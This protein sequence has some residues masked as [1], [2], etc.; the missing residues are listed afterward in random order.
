MVSD[1]K[2]A[3][4]KSM[5]ICKHPIMQCLL[6]VTLS[7]WAFRKDVWIGEFRYNA[8]DTEAGRARMTELKQ[9][10]KFRQ[11]DGIPVRCYHHYGITT[12]ICGLDSERNDVDMALGHPHDRIA[13]I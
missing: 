8:Y 4:Y 10:S 13:R 12:L 2:R 1:Y 3:K 5:F 7:H 6:V 11:V 9:P